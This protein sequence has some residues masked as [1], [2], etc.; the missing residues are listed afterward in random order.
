MRIFMFYHPYKKVLPLL[1]LM[2]LLAACGTSTNSGTQGSSSSAS[3]GSSTGSQQNS[4]TTT[5]TVKLGQ[6][7]CPSAVS[8][9]SY[10]DQ[11][12]GT[13]P[14]VSKVVSVAC[15]NLTG[16]A[17]LQALVNVQ[18]NGANAS[19][20]VY[21]YDQI[22]DPQ[23]KQLFKLLNLIQGDAKISAYNTVITAEVD[24]Q[25]SKNAN[26]SSSN[27]TVDLFREFKW[28]DGAGTLVPVSFPGLFPYLSR[29]EAEAGQ[30]DVNQGKNAWQL[31]VKQV[32]SNFVTMLLQW[33][34]NA[35]VSIASG[36]GKDDVDAVVNVKSPNP[37][38]NSVRLTMSRLEGN[39]NGG[40]WIITEATT[41]GLAITTPATRDRISS[42][43]TVSGKGNAFEG[44]I[45]KLEILDHTYTA[46]GSVAQV[47]GSPGMGN[48]S[49]ST[50]VKYT[51]TFTKG[52]QEGIVVLFSYSQ[53][54]GSIAGTAMVKVLLA[55]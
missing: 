7:P 51:S 5:A 39:K 29:Y 23:P 21:V 50:S 2:L 27:Q 41:D 36:G 44:Q 54:D 9:T 33:S 8:A 53:A 52:S 19:Q 49:F 37:G 35:T 45:G 42:P 22:S 1:L 48:A 18:A 30:K 13:Q 6:Q 10:W 15:G 26:A 20:D 40:V 46:I 12:V 47:K 4:D 25:S 3:A 28:S 14:D 55:P 43:V 31:D 11:I 38:G 24:N 16:R 32:A 34:S 17:T